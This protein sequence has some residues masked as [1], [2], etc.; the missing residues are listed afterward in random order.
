MTIRD[1]TAWRYLA[2][3]ATATWRARN[4]AKILRKD[5]ARTTIEIDLTD[6]KVR[7]VHL[8]EDTLLIPSGNTFYVRG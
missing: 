8:I 2:R 5:R 1:A 6:P 7:E 4:G 3:S